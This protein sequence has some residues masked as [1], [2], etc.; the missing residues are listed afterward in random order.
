MYR[1]RIKPFL[2]FISAVLLF[3]VLLPV[4]VTVATVLM[5]SNGGSPFFFFFF[6]NRLGKGEKMFTIIK[7]KTMNDRKDAAGKLLP[8]GER[9]TVIGNFLRKISLDEIPQLLNV[10]HFDMSFVD[11]RPV[12]SEYLPLYNDQQRNSHLVKPGIT[13]WAQVNGR[14]SISWKKKV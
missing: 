6:Q 13:G 7:F 14:N 12:L 3:C 2:D 5:I 11:P 4:I 10:I 9:L 8:D 1:N